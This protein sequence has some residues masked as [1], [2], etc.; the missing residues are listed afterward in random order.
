M[1]GSSSS[2]TH[3]FVYIG[4]Q[5]P[6]P[7]DTVEVR[8]SVIGYPFPTAPN[9]PKQEAPK[10]WWTS[11]FWRYM[12]LSIM[13]SATCTY[14]PHDQNKSGKT[15][16]ST[17]IGSCVHTTDRN[18]VGAI[19]TSYALKSLQI[20]LQPWFLCCLKAGDWHGA[21][22]LDIRAGV[23]VLLWIY[24]DRKTLR[25]ILIVRGYIYPAHAWWHS[26]NS[27]FGGKSNKIRSSPYL[28]N[29]ISLTEF[30]PTGRRPGEPGGKSFIRKLELWSTRLISLSRDFKYSC[31]VQPGS[32]SNRWKLG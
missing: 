14:V 31:P 8:S 15:R 20:A 17:I 25:E 9:W 16:W 5:T 29:R 11:D 32:F 28:N 22:A 10:A 7:W 12:Y 23:C 26:W 30:R 13:I 27:L 19:H 3:V 2:P 24:R 21:L 1:L 4:P 6:E 18:K